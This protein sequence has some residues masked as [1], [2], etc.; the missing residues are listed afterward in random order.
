MISMDFIKEKFK[1]SG[2]KLTNQR[3]AVIEVLIEN[4]HQFLSAED[5]F[6]K[7]KEKCSQTD[8]STIYRNL[9]VLENIG[10]I[11]RT[12][13]DM[14]SSL[15]QITCSSGHHHHIICKICGKT[16]VIDFCPIDDIKSSITLNDFTVTDH[17]IELYGYCK[18]C[19][20]KVED[21]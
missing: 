12:N 4:E 5:I 8:L 1:K 13:M 21:K 18:N 11:H 17:K 10:I 14:G 7:S 3:K 2:Y 15:Y 9:D 16:G 19:S 20:I 6:I